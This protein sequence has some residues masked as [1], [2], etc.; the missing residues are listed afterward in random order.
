VEPTSPSDDE[1]VAVGR[2]VKPHGIRGEVVVALLTDRDERFAPESVLWAAGRRFEVISSRPHQGRLLVRLAGIDERTPA[3]RL[4]GTVLEAVRDE[5]DEPDVYLADELVG[6]PVV[7]ADGAALGRVA[8]LI[9]LPDAAGYD[10]LEVVREDGSPWLLPASE[11][12]ATLDEIEGEL[13]IVLTDAAAR[14]LE[15]PEGDGDR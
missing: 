9:E 13:R 6:L 4:R 5:L 8:A 7:G 15:E 3:E 14:L 2:I 12:L 1:L 10:L 11:D